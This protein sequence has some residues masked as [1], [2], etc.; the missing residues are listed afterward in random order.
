MQRRCRAWAVL[1][2]V[3]GVISQA[4]AAMDTPGQFSVSQAGAA[5]YT[6]PIQVPTGLQGIQPTLALVYDG[7]NRNGP[8]GVGWSLQ[9]LS[10]I[11]RCP[12]TIAQDNQ[13]GRVDYSA[14]DRFC[15]D[16][17]RL[18]AI[19]GTYG[20]SG[21]EYRTEREVFSRVVSNGTAGSGPASFT[22]D[23]KDGLTLEYGATTDSRRRVSSTNATARSWALSEIRD[24]NGNYLSVSYLQTADGSAF[25]PS[26]LGWG[27]NKNVSTSTHGHWVI[28]G[29]GSQ[30]TD[31]ETGYAAG[32][33]V[34][35]QYLVAG[36]KTFTSTTNSSGVPSW[37]QT[38]YVK[39]YQLQYQ[40]S[41]TTQRNRL[42]KVTEYGAGF[43]GGSKPP[44]QFSWNDAAGGITVSSSSVAV[45]SGDIRSNY[46]IFAGDFN[47]D[48]I[49]DVVLFGSSSSHFCSG[50]G[51]GPLTSCTQIGTGDWRTSYSKS[52]DASNL[53]RT[54][55]LVGDFNGDGVT[56]LYL[57]GPSGASFCAGPGISQSNNCTTPSAPAFAGWLGAMRYVGDFNG[58][59]ISD[60]V[61]VA[62]SGSYFCAGPGI[63]QSD[64]C[65]P[66]SGAATWHDTYS[67]WSVNVPEGIFPGDF[68]GD[69]TTDL[70][71]IGTAGTKFCPGPGLAGANT[72]VQ[73]HASDWKSAYSITQGD[74]NGDGTADL[75]LA[76]ATNSMYCAGPGIS[77]ANNCTQIATG[78]WKSGFKNIAGDFNG[79][80]K[81]DL[82]R[83]G[84]SASHFC[85]GPGIT[86]T[87]SCIQTVS[88]DWR[89]TY[90]VV[91]SDFNGDGTSDFYLAGTTGG[92]LAAGAA[93]QS[94]VV[95]SIQSGLGVTVTPTYATL[96]EAFSASDKAYFRD[97]NFAYP[98]SFYLGPMRVVK[99]FAVSDGIGGTRTFKYTY[100]NGAVQ[101]DGRGFLGFGWVQKSDELA[102][103]VE[104]TDYIQAF[105]FTGW[106]SSIQTQTAAAAPLAE[107]AYSYG[108]MDFVS[109]SGC[110]LSPGRRYFVYPAQSEVKAWDIGPGGT[111]GPA[112]P[113]VRST[114]SFDAYG[115]L[116][117]STATTLNADS[118]PTG[119][120][121]TT[122]NTFAPPDLT[123]WIH[124]RLIRSTVTS[125]TP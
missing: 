58:D 6:I 113:I 51:L 77:Q 50:P 15:L 42:V 19:N 88:G 71:L 70:L 125:T 114:S 29:V 44:T 22:V 53:V 64:N 79:D 93:G 28:I 34:K 68:D 87:N 78:D 117:S 61:Q 38:D 107:T 10:S 4:N 39:H 96:P 82:Y 95:G 9:G 81:A 72:C 11:T 110:E 102:G 98:Q 56:D 37:S 85:P 75:L 119:F 116:T 83:I 109:A 32:A 54:N 14:N 47:G 5:T 31:Q 57:V 94:D 30:R 92:Y 115:N 99:R 59:G 76:G 7:G 3:F 106:P 89:N 40:P 55:V 8:L 100:G 48:G 12:L 1:L 103:L 108:C 105:P 84:T 17:Q 20:V 86:S 111:P 35:N 13:R 62:A 67:G 16:G 41:P 60:L 23:T 80:G 27:A 74:F 36:I 69:G 21:T 124:G 46:D 91:T 120:G 49:A 118:S 43:S 25:A 66:I 63:A 121:T 24:K 90:T 101:A 45:A 2:G 26:T 33:F 123:K 18:V 104:R 52:P 97:A 122:I 73:V 65:V 112:L